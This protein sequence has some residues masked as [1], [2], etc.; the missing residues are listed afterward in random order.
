MI[1]FLHLHRKY[2]EVMEEAG[3]L[4]DFEKLMDVLENAYEAR[5]L[6][7]GMVKVWEAY[8]ILEDTHRR[9]RKHISPTILN[10]LVADTADIIESTPLTP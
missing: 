3:F 2:A 10:N 9:A 4:T 1:A 8:T 6:V 7:E 5:D